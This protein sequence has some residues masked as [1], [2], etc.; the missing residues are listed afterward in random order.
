MPTGS[1]TDFVEPGELDRSI[2]DLCIQLEKEG[3]RVKKRDR[4]GLRYWCPARTCTGH[5]LYV[6]TAKLVDARLEWQL[7][8]SCLTWTS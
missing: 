7:E 3:W 1:Y 4:R 2:E 8:N 5:E 6:D